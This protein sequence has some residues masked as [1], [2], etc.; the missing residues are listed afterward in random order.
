[1]GFGIVA[2]E[3]FAYVLVVEV[4]VDFVMLAV[5]EQEAVY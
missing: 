3:M 1:M 5:E 4:A 2:V